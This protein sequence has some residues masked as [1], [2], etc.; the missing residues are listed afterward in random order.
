MISYHIHSATQHSHSAQPLSPSQLKKRHQ[1]AFCRMSQFRQNIFLENT[2]PRNRHIN[3]NGSRI[4]RKIAH[5][6]AK[7]MHFGPKSVIFL[8]GDFLF[9]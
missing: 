2:F 9:F 8:L 7:I 6:G 1:D 4:W 5:F 3:T